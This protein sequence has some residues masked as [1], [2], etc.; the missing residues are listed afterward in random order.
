MHAGNKTRPPKLLAGIEFAALSAMANESKLERIFSLSS[1]FWRVGGGISLGVAAG[2]D[3][4]E[5][6][7]LAPGLN[8]GVIGEG[9]DV[10]VDSGVLA[11]SVVSVVS[12]VS[13]GLDGDAL[14]SS[15]G[16]AVATLIAVSESMT[17]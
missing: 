3:S 13:V 12:V 2:A 15:L 8:G 4:R 16:K 14:S 5:V 9:G 10:S 7:E 1:E 6:E 17:R 11:E